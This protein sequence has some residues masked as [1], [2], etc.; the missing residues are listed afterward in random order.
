MYKFIAI[1]FSLILSA[2]CC[3]S[4]NS[5]HF[6]QRKTTTKAKIETAHDTTEKNFIGLSYMFTNY[7][8]FE[9]AIEILKP[10]SSRYFLAD[11]IKSKFNLNFAIYYKRLLQQNHA[12]QIELGH[13]SRIEESFNLQINSPIQV[14]EL[15]LTVSGLYSWQFPINHLLSAQWSYG[16]YTNLRMAS[17]M[18]SENRREIPIE[19]LTPTQQK[20]ATV[21]QIIDFAM[22]CK[23]KSVRRSILTGKSSYST[24]SAGLRNNFD[25]LS[26]NT[27][28]YISWTP[29]LGIMYMF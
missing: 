21:G 2:L 19:L 27:N 3:F 28:Q 16:F 10:K 13:A 11:E 9:S 6:N 29:Y 5:K 1:T 18:L 17:A 24:T 25:L 22:N 20:A 26:I 8:N 7:I 4:Q 15:F 23:M 12:F 14:R